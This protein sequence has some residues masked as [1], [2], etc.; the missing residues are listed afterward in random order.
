M[1]AAQL[2]NAN[3]LHETYKLFPW[4][5]PH[6]G[7][8]PY[9]DFHEIDRGHYVD[10]DFALN[11]PEIVEENYLSYENHTVTTKDGY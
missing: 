6:W 9:G 10:K 8:V 7:P 1:M 4:L 5:Q 3:I 2:A 11:F